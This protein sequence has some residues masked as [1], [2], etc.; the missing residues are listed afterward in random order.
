MLGPHLTEENHREV[1]ARAKHRS[2]REIA[3]LVRMLDPL[4]YVPA[5]VEPLK[6]TPAGVAAHSGREF[7]AH[8]KPR[9]LRD[10][11]LPRST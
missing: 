10:D 9:A 3:R 5:V 8:H 7:I 2:K 6:P 4:P 11:V 1:L